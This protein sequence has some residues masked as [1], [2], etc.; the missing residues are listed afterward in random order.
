VWI[1][2][3]LGF[4]AFWLW[5]YVLRGGSR[6]GVIAI[7]GH[8]RMAVL[9]GLPILGIGALLLASPPAA[10]RNPQLAAA[11]FEWP[12]TCQRRVYRISDQLTRRCLAALPRISRSIAKA[13]GFDDGGRGS[14]PFYRLGNDAAAIS[15]FPGTNRCHIRNIHR[16]VFVVVG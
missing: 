15:C 16:H 3:L 11:T 1:C 9:L 4:A 10:Y 6:L 5:A 2:W 14:A 8:R 13:N 12:A 7:E